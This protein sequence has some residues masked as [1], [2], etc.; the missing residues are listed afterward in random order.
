MIALFDAAAKAF[1][2]IDGVVNNAGTLERGGA[3]RGYD[4]RAHP[5]D[6]RGQPARIAACRPRGSAAHGEEPWRSRAARSSISPRPRRSS[7][8][9]GEFVDYAA[10]KGGIEAMNI[11]LSKEL[12]KE[13]IRVNAIRPGLIDTE[14]QAMTGGIRVAPQRLGA[15]DTDGPAGDRRRSRRGDRVAPLRRGVLRQRRRAR[16]DRRSLRTR[17]P[18]LRK[19]TSRRAG[20]SGLGRTRRRASASEATGGRA[21]LWNA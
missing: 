15:D 8:A 20:I 9:P 17:D 11:G 21:A 3:A 1:G 16:R 7:A 6:D 14:I 5:A 19:R 18:F 2:P 13:G 10:T 4:A 12:G